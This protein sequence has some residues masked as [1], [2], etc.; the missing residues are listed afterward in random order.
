M[1]NKLPAMLDNERRE[2]IS[3]YVREQDKERSICA[4]LLLRHGFLEWGYTEDEWKQVKVI[5][6][7]HGK[8]RL[9]SYPDFHYSL[10]H[11]GEWVI[12]AVDDAQIGVDIQEMKEIKL[13]LARRFY[14]PD[15][16]ER[17][18]GIEKQELQRKEFYTM[19][20]AKESYVKLT[21]RGIGEGIR[22]YVTEHSYQQMQDEK[23]NWLADIKIYE[24]IP[25]YIVCVCTR[26]E[27]KAGQLEI[28]SGIQG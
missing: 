16:Y 17:L 4:G 7:A 19:W 26:E 11:S 12:C 18:I 15:E 24:T 6:E 9:E 1:E 21:G 28:V 2:Q 22:Q 5:R 27:A 8:P 20:A 14:H 3:R 13:A 23:G 10:S 25:D